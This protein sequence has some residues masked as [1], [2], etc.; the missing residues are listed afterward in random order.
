MSQRCSAGV[1][2]LYFLPCRSC[3]G[4]DLEGVNLVAQRTNCRGSSSRSSREKAHF[5]KS[6]SPLVTLKYWRNA[7]EAPLVV[8][9]DISCK[10]DASEE[11]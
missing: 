10:N 2:R 7:N 6:I 5:N 3:N 9:S 11:N 8:G 1:C 4:W